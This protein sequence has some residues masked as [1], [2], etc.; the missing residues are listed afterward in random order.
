MFGSPSRDTPG[1]VHTLH[2][3]LER[4]ASPDLTAAEADALRPR[5]LGLLNAAEPGN[6]DR[7]LAAAVDLAIAR[8]AERCVVV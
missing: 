6:A 3:L 2:S 1:I 8:G 5:L 4:L 7:S